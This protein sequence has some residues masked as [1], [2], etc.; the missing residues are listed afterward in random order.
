MGPAASPCSAHCIAG[1][2]CALHTVEKAGAVGGWF[3]GVTM[4]GHDDGR[5]ILTQAPSTE[6]FPV[7][8]SV[9][10]HE[11]HDIGNGLLAFG[12]DNSLGIFAGVWGVLLCAL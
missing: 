10:Y 1:H 7:I 3:S 2:H 12:P 11:K 8:S 9:K 4:T 6:R 5:S